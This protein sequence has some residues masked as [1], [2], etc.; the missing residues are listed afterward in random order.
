VDV[1]VI[2]GFLGHNL[3][4]L[5]FVGGHVHYQEDAAVSAPSQHLDDA[6]VV[7]L[8]PRGL[9]FVA[10][11]DP[12]RHPRANVG[13]ELGGIHG[14]DL[15]FGAGHAGLCARVDAQQHVFAKDLVAADLAHD[16]V[17][18]VLQLHGPFG[19]QHHVFRRVSDGLHFFARCHDVFH[20]LVGQVQAVLV[21]AVRERVHP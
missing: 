7:E 21:V 3:E 20:H 6:Q 16:F 5:E 2:D 1:V 11:L 19:Q 17:L 18:I 10:L 8:Y 9:Q 14:L 15:D 4:G 12:L 13:V